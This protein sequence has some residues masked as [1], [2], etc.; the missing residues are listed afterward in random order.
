MQKSTSKNPLLVVPETSC[1]SAKIDKGRSK[2]F[3]SDEGRRVPKLSLA[4]EQPQSCTGASLGCSRARD[5]F[6]TFRPS[7]EKTTCSLPILAEKQEFGACTTQSGQ[8]KQPNTKFL[9]GKTRGRW[10]G[11]LGG[12]PSPFGKT[13]HP[14]ARSAGKQSFL[15][16]R[17]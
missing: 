12:R 7:P 8:E 11:Y 1:L 14:I 17:P 9:A 3:F 10:G 2:S 4:L 6:G 13:F 15:R 16:G 5:I